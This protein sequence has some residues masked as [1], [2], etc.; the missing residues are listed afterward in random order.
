MGASGRARSHP[1]SVV[2]RET[3]AAYLLISR[4]GHTISEASASVGS[5]NSAQRVRRIFVGCSGRIFVGCSGVFLCGVR[6]ICVR[7]SAGADVTATG[8]SRFPVAVA[9]LPVHGATGQG[10]SLIWAHL[11]MISPM[12]RTHHI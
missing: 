11:L 8:V 2:S 3:P 6:R 10:V 7:R 5:H 12:R 9:G 4:A 1:V